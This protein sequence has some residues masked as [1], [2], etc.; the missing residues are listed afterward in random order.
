MHL[1][2]ENATV[3]HSNAME[4]KYMML[5]IISHARTFHGEILSTTGTPARTFYR[6]RK[7]LPVGLKCDYETWLTA[8][9]CNGK[10]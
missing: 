3:T 5:I 2:T 6:G 9:R 4:E 1:L 10:N 7:E 8:R